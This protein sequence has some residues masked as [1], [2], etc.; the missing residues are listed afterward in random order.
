MLPLIRLFVFAWAMMIHSQPA[1]IGDDGKYVPNQRILRDKSDT[2]QCR[3]LINRANQVRDSL[4]NYKFA[5]LIYEKTNSMLQQQS[6]SILNSLL[7]YNW[8]VAYFFKGNY[9]EADNLYQKALSSGSLD[10]QPEFKAKILHNAGVNLSRMK[11]YKRAMTYFNQALEIYIQ[12]HNI[13]GIGSVYWNMSGLLNAV[14]DFSQ[15]EQ[16]LDKM[17]KLFKENNMSEDERAIL[18]RKA[19]VKSKRKD[20]DGAKI[21][22]TQA[23]LI[24]LKRPKTLP[25]DY[26]TINLEEAYAQAYVSIGYCYGELEKWD[27]CFY[28]L[29]RGKQIADSLR[30]SYSFDGRYYNDMG[31]NYD[32]KEDYKKAIYYYKKSLAIKK[33]NS[34]CRF[35]IENIADIYFANKQYDSAFFYKEEAIR[36]AD[37][38]Y[39]SELKEHVTFEDKRIE[40]LEKDYRDQVLVNTQQRTLSHLEKRNYLLIAAVIILII[41]MVALS[42]YFRQYRLKIK[43]EHLQ[44]E[45]DFLRAQLNPHFLF[46][47][48]NNIYVLMDE[49]KNRASDILLKFSELM[50]YQLYDCNVESIQLSKELRFLEN[51]IEFEQLRYSNKIQV[52]Y[53]ADDADTSDL[54]IVPLLLQPFIENAFKHTPKNKDQQSHVQVRW[55]LRGK[56]F[57]FFV[58]NSVDAE[59]VSDLPG[60]IGLKNVEKRLKLLYPKKHELN[61]VKTD[62]DYTITLKLTLSND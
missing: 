54:L 19:S 41:L 11:V 4:H 2:M 33:G 50:R 38:L 29:N 61:M 26:P 47:S 1:V 62:L 58:S 27:S 57:S 28:F 12:T 37:S 32:L 17:F 40:L 52:S 9:Q 30:I 49:N 42:F 6:N 22:L 35:L 59:K 53:S 34:N 5:I 23:L 46:N 25:N 13:R 51:Y 8:G 10:K 24:P 44:S 3:L 60:G 20:F 36:F 55:S 18:I 14:G 43:K 45:L 31:Y 39:A 15:A 56:E 16:L 21:L 7:Y 48:I